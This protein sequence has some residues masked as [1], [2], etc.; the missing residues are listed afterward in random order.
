MPQR[1]GVSNRQTMEFQMNTVRLFAHSVA[2]ASVCFLVSCSTTVSPPATAR[3][4]VL[5]LCTCGPDCKCTTVSTK[6]GKC[7]CNHDLAPGHVVK[8][9][10]DVALCCGCGLECM[11]TL[12]ANNPAQCTCGKPI[13]RQSLKGTGIYF[14]NCGSSCTCNTVSEQPGKCKCGMDLKR[15]D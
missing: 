9:E 2:L 5:Y 4:D 8:V 3:Q 14:C 10:G 1:K 15:V 11:C 13:R 12:D 6:P 7:A